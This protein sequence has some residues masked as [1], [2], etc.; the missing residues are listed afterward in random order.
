MTSQYSFDLYFV[1]GKIELVMGE[2]NHPSSRHEK[3]VYLF[4]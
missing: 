4:H 2:A 3:F 1:M